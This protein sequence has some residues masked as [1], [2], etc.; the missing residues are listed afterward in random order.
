M[1]ET[2]SEITKKYRALLR[3][4]YEWTKMYNFLHKVELHKNAAILYG[5]IFTLKATALTHHVPHVDRVVTP[6]I[7]LSL[8]FDVQYKEGDLI[9]YTKINDAL[10]DEIKNR[11]ISILKKFRCI[12][13]FNGKRSVLYLLASKGDET[14]QVE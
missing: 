12:E 1:T 6:P 8:P 2:K 4:Q 9:L 14:C 13:M 10:S 11:V 3:G 7:I 5:D